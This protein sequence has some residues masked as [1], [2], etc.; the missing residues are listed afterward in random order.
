MSLT[1]R[2]GPVKP[3][4][5]QR[6]SVSIST[7]DSKKRSWREVPAALVSVGDTVAEFGLV[8]GLFLNEN[9]KIVTLVNIEG[10]EKRLRILDTV[11]A[12]Q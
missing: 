6:K 5:F 8:E 4:P 3:K 7:P 11:L 10:D 9:G 2:M 12:F 1:R